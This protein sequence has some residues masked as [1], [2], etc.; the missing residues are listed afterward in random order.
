MANIY[1]DAGIAMQRFILQKSVGGSWVDSTKYDANQTHRFKALFHSYYQ[2]GLASMPIYNTGY[3]YVDIYVTDL[4]VEMK[5]PGAIFAGWQQDSGIFQLMPGQF[6]GHPDFNNVLKPGASRWFTFG[7]FVWK[8]SD[9]PVSSVAV[10][11][12]TFHREVCN[13]PMAPW[14]NLV[15]G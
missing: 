7:D 12:Y 14:A 5:L 8:K 4:R 3:G 1:T 13:K 2:T 11:L 10:Q 9:T 15:A 6:D